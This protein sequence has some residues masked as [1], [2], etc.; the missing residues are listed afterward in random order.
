MSIL[1]L[2]LTK[3]V[4]AL[5]IL[6]LLNLVVALQVNVYAQFYH[7]PAPVPE[8]IQIR[9]WLE[10][11]LAYPETELNKKIQ[12]TVE[13]SFI[14][15]KTGMAYNYHITGSVSEPLDREAIRLVRKMRWNPATNGGQAVDARHSYS[16][17]FNIRQYNRMLRQRGYA[18]RELP[19]FP[20]D[21]SQI[22]YNFAELEQAPKPIFKDNT[23]TL[24]RYIQQEI[25]Y[26]NA[27][28]TLSLSGTVSLGYVVEENGLVS[29][30]HVINSVGGGCDNEAIRI[31]QSIDWMPGIKN[32][33]AVRSH[34]KLDIIFR[35]PDGSRQNAIPNQQQRS[36]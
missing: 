8:P 28:L 26:P 29:N 3:E 33:M 20:A 34:G 4:M 11:E 7:P 13:V 6:L 1:V 12:G 31:L 16:I 2:L 9:T 22:I 35:L 5:K 25:N 30:I 19:Y 36:M 27:A 32:G 15:D 23:V 17:R 24:N 21:T 18:I 14:I 10:K